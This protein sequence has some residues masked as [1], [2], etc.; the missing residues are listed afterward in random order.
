[1]RT[2]IAT[3]FGTTG[4]LQQSDVPEPVPGPGQVLVDVEAVGVLW[5]DTQIRQG[6]GPDG[7]AVA[8]PYVPG[9]SVGGTVSAAGP[10]ADDTWLGRRVLTHAAAGGYAEQVLADATA[11]VAV[12][13]GLGLPEATA[14][15]D[16]GSTA[17]ALLER[18]PVRPSVPASTCSRPRA[19]E[20][21]VAFDGVGGSVG[22]GASA[23]VAAGGRFSSYGVAGGSPTVV[24]AERAITATGMEHREEPA[25]RLRP[26]QTTMP[27]SASSASRPLPGA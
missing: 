5:L 12:P 17:L 3:A 10:G 22:A 7:F 18:T 4:V 21:A 6:H 20:P 8:P 13:D 25:G 19:G 27:S 1:M 26:A 15:L 16:D 11:L 23:L 9:G 2:I 24:P 14:L